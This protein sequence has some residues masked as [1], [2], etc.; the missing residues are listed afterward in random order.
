MYRGKEIWSNGSSLRDRGLNCL[1]LRIVERKRVC[2]L[3]YLD[4]RREKLKRLS[5]AAEEVERTD[6]IDVTAMGIAVSR[7]DGT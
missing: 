7:V 1:V 5:Q 3:T 2:A 4:I 6:G